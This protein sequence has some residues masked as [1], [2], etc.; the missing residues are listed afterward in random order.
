MVCLKKHVDADILDALRVFFFNRY[1]GLLTIGR[2]AA[3]TTAQ[4]GCLPVQRPRPQTTVSF[5]RPLQIFHQENQ[6]G[7]HHDHSGSSRSR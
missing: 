4:T 3:F 2:A 7:F 6:T 1:S 5:R